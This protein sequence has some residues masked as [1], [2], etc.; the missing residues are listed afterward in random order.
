MKWANPLA[1]L[2]QAGVACLRNDKQTAISLLSKASAGFEEAHMKL[3]AAV[4][5]RRL[6]EISGGAEGQVL[7]DEADL[8]MREQRIKAPTRITRMLA[9]GIESSTDYTNRS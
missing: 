4:A 6:G 5:K 1:A 3:Y 9:P 7:I 2:L 8:W